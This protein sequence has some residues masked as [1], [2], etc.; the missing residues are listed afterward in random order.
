MTRFVLDA[1]FAMTWVIE[2]ERTPVSLKH[3]NALTRG[4][5]QGLVPALWC[6]ELANVLLTVERARQIS[7]AVVS[8]WTDYFLALPLIVHPASLEQ[9][10]IEI[11]PL[12]QAHG[13]SVYDASYLH[14]A[15][16]EQ[17]PLATFDRQLIKEARKVGVELLE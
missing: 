8:T 15:M 6:D 3:F 12:A 11:R 7:A 17:V 5:A 4:H 1:S 13:L 2:A 10:L 16:R 9:S 14:L